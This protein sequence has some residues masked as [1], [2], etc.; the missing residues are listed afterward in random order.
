VHLLPR[1]GEIYFA[2]WY[3]ICVEESGVV[4]TTCSL[5]MSDQNIST[6][7]DSDAL[8]RTCKNVIEMDLAK[9]QIDSWDE[10]CCLIAEKK[11]QHFVGNFCFAVDFGS[12]KVAVLCVIPQVLDNW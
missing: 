6:I 5:I 7:G 9:N 10:V 3:L 11:C 1:F 4:V 8:K 12:A 2:Q